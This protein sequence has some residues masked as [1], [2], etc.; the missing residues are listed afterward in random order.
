MLLAY[1]DPTGVTAAF[2]LNL[3]GRL[4]RE[5]DG[6]IDLRRF[7]HQA[8]WNDRER[9]IEMHLLSLVNQ[10]ASVPACGMTVQFRAGET[11]WTESSHKFFR[12]EMFALAERSGFRVQAQ[13]VDREWPFV[14]SLWTA[15]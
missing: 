6:D 5:F 15:R 9:R 8:R 12:E 2:N 13:W 14:E 4:N 7:Q 11:I 1:A 10:T 3:L